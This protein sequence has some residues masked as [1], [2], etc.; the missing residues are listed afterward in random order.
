MSFRVTGVHVGVVLFQFVYMYLFVGAGPCGQVV[1]QYCWPWGWFH[2][3]GAGLLANHWVK[4]FTQALV[5]QMS[6]TEVYIL[7]F[8]SYFWAHL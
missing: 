5:L 4:S 8:K 7:V 2:P 1:I 6:F 3:A